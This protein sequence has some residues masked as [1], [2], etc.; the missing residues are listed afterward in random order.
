MELVPTAAG[1]WVFPEVKPCSHESWLRE[2]P[3]SA[4]KE[5]L[6]ALPGVTAVLPLL[7]FYL[8]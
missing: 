5:Q 1:G 6:P 2:H 7:K 4:G 3:C 8:P